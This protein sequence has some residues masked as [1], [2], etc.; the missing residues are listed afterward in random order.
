MSPRRVSAKFR[1][2]DDPLDAPYR[3]VARYAPVGLSPL[4]RNAVRRSSLFRSAI[5]GTARAV[6]APSVKVVPTLRL[7]TSVRWRMILTTGLRQ[8]HS[9]VA[10][11][12]QMRL[13][14]DSILPTAQAFTRE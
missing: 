5:I 3:P 10:L 9:R 4:W 2:A 14:D 6:K 13:A 1:A 7:P 11:D 12:D 8:V